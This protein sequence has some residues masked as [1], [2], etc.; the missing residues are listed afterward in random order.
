MWTLKTCA[1]IDIEP[2]HTTI[3][4]QPFNVI[5]ELAVGTCAWPL[6][7]RH[8]PGTVLPADF[9]E[10]VI[11]GTGFAGLNPFPG[12]VRLCRC[13]YGNRGCA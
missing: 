3:R 8:L 6:R 7:I 10:N 12:T 5:V 11:Q 2:E 13:R 1:R 9:R 4:R